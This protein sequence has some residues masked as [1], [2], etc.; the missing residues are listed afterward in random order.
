MAGGGGYG[1]ALERDP[2]SVRADLLDG[3][4][5]RE[6]A[7]AAYGVVLD[8]QAEIDTD[9]TAALRAAH[10]RNASR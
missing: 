5:S 9:A 8:L 4:I 7:R 6:H 10:L 3:K 2:Q 1:N